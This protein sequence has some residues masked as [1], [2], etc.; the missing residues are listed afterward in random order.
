MVNEKACKIYAS[1]ELS[2][3]D[4]TDEETLDNEKQQLLEQDEQVRYLAN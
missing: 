4:D 1:A 3:I 2:Y